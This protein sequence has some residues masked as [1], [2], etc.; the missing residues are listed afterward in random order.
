MKR[1]IMV[2]CMILFASYTFA[3]SGGKDCRGVW[4]QVVVKKLYSVTCK[5]PHTLRRLYTKARLPYLD[6]ACADDELCLSPNDLKKNPIYSELTEA[7]CV[8]V[9]PTPY[10]SDSL[11]KMVKAKINGKVF[12]ITSTCASGE[13]CQSGQCV[14]QTAALCKD[15]DKTIVTNG[16]PDWTSLTTS[17]QVTL[18]TGEVKKDVC[19]DES[20][21]QEQYCDP[22]TGAAKMAYIGC[23]AIDPSGQ[24]ESP[25]IKIEIVEGQEK[26]VSYTA[27]CLFGKLS[28]DKDN[29]D[30]PDTFDNCP[31][32]SNADQKDSDSDGVGDACQIVQV[33]T[34]GQHACYLKNSQVFCWGSNQWGQLGVD[35]K[36]VPSATQEKPVTV[37]GLDSVKQIAAGYA[38][39]CAIMTLDGRVRCWGQNDKGQLGTCSIGPNNLPP[40]GS[41]CQIS[42]KTQTAIEDVKAIALGGKHSCALMSNGTVMCWGNNEQGQLGYGS[43]MDGTLF[44]VHTPIATLVQGLSNA[45]SIAAGEYH[46]CATLQDGSY[47]CWGDNQIGELGDLTAAKFQKTPIVV[48]NVKNAQQMALGYDHSCVLAEFKKDNLIN[49]HVFCWG[50]NDAGQLGDP[51]NP[52]EKALQYS[53]SASGS[54]GPLPVGPNFVQQISSA[55]SYTCALLQDG[56]LRC[57]GSLCTS[58]P[59]KTIIPTPE[60]PLPLAEPIKQ[61]SVGSQQVCYLTQKNAV[62]CFNNAD[63]KA[64]T[65]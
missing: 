25:C 37:A 51:S 64:P 26:C 12:E 28:N 41:V 33:A 48:P 9:D 62:G 39:T 16:K 31:T 4:C 30:V 44:N 63:I 52:G 6:I 42:G 10:C 36:I 46:T 29:D 13:V 54:Q 57:W 65:P 3:V 56:S 15:S 35:P 20:F 19:K 24:C 50:K 55:G 32:T 27:K 17:G 14:S 1:L 7:S 8:S 59:V 21:L 61:V 47:A 11:N 45:G 43:A 22:T 23:K 49:H 60:N 34:G 18:A 53:D 5:D 2:S 38:H 58:C 40:A